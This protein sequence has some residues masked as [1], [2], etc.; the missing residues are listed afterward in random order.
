MVMLRLW[1]TQSQNKVTGN[2]LDEQDLMKRMRDLKD[3]ESLDEVVESAAEKDI[4]DDLPADS[5]D[6]QAPLEQVA[7]PPPPPQEAEEAEEA[8]EE[9]VEEV[10][11]RKVRE[12]KGICDSREAEKDS[13]QEAEEEEEESEAEAVEEPI[14]IRTLVAEGIRTTQHPADDEFMSRQST[15]EEREGPQQPMDDDHHADHQADEAD[16]A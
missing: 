1:M 9:E 8:E 15:M 5:G 4:H 6:V 7:L 11:E 13:D 3:S 2:S 12:E 14:A 16:E 10:E